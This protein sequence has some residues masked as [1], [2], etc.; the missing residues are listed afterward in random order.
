MD[1]APAVIKMYTLMSWNTM[2]VS[3]NVAIYPKLRS[4]GCERY[5]QSKYFS[6]SS[7]CIVFRTILGSCLP[8]VAVPLPV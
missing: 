5:G 3:R 7:C 4:R 2:Q 1:F 8:L 6:R